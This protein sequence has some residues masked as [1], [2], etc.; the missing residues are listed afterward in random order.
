M[1]FTSQSILL[2]QKLYSEKERENER[3]KERKGEGGKRNKKDEKGEEKTVRG[4]NVFVFLFTFSLP[5]LHLL[6]TVSNKNK[7]ETFFR[8]KKE[9]LLKTLLLD[10]L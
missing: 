10:T 5:S 3:R 8:L 1:Y 6:L 2:S 7:E 4:W 9:V